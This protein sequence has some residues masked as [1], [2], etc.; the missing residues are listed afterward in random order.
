MPLEG[1]VLDVPGPG[2]YE[3][4]STVV[5]K[6]TTRIGTSQRSRMS[7]NIDTPG[8]GAY[9]SKDKTN[10]PNFGFGTGK[11]GERTT[12]QSHGPGPGA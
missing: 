5:N 8:P 3:T 4:Y 7:D 1:N 6:P 2:K 11:R 10:A 12:S 9:T